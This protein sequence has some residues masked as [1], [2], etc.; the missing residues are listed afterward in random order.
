MA[1]LI[2]FAFAWLFSLVFGVVALIFA[3]LGYAALGIWVVAGTV[4]AQIAHP[5]R[6]FGH[7]T[8]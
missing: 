5:T 7:A 3:A 4:A 1:G 8:A 6:H 2:F